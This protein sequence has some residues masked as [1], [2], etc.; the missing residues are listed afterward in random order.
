MFGFD[1]PSP[2]I[3]TMAIEI[4]AEFGLI[5]RG[6][7]YGKGRAIKVRPPLICGQQHI[8]ELVAKLDRTFIKLAQK[9][10]AA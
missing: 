3:A 8:D 1:T 4:A 2:D 7:R 5:I 6:S 9:I 10:N